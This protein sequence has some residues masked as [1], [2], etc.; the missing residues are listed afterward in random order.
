MKGAREAWAINGALPWLLLAAVRFHLNHVVEL[1]LCLVGVAL[2][3]AVV[4]AMN[5][6]IAS[7]ETSFRA[8]RDAVFGSATHV[9]RSPSGTID[10]QIYKTLRFEH[11]DLASAPVVQGTVMVPGD[12]R[13]RLTLLGIDPLVDQ[14]VRRHAP[15]P[16]GDEQRRV[17][18]LL[19]YPASAWASTE[20]LA[21][22]GITVGQSIEVVAAAGQ[23]EITVIAE[24]TPGSKLEAIG[25]DGVLMTDISSAQEIL[26]LYGR[27]SR[28]D[29][30]LPEASNARIDALAQHLPA[31][32]RIERTLA[33]ARAVS[34]LSAS[35]YFNLR[36]LSLL[37]LVVGLFIIYNAM[38]FAVVR[39]RR[40]IGRLA[41]IGVT[42]RE[43]L[44]SVLLETLLLSSIGALLGI[45]L[46]I[47]L[48]NELL[49]LISRTV[50]DLYYPIDANRLVLSAQALTHGILL[51]LAGSVLAG[52]APALEAT[53]VAP[54][55]AMT[56][57]QLERR[58]HRRA[59][60]LAGVAV[61]V[62]MLV[63]ML[64][65]VSERSLV[66]GYVVLLFMVV[67]GVL[68][69][70]GLVLLFS[71]LASSLTQ[72]FLSPQWS[73]GLR[74]LSAG[75]SRSAVA[76]AALGVALATT[77]GMAV[78]VD[79]FRAS[80]RQ[81]L[82]ITLE[83]DVYV[84]VGDRSHG[85]R[86]SDELVSQ[87]AR[88]PEVRALSVS[89]DSQVEIDGV[90]VWLK[91]L[92]VDG[93]RYRDIAMID[94]A[95]DGWQSLSQPNAVLISEPLAWRERLRV[96]DELRLPVHGGQHAFKVAGVFRDYGSERG[97]IMMSRSQYV[98]LFANTGY[99]GVGVHG[100][101]GVSVQQLARAVETLTAQQPGLS[102]R[103]NRFIRQASFEIF[104]RTFLI[105]RVMQWLATLVA[106]V[107]VV[108]ALMSMALERLR[109]MAVLRAQ[110][111]TRLELVVV[112]QLQNA[113]L[114]LCAGLLACPLGIAMSS[115]LV[116]VINQRAFGWSTDFTLSST[117][118]LSTGIL[119]VVA[120][121]VAGAYPSWRMAN[122]P[123]ADALRDM[124]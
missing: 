96:G 5:L 65:W 10:E 28:I 85:N 15:Q 86:I 53:R 80:F 83:A 12:N 38:T 26:N 72:S 32:V 103:S 93:D 120:A 17:R 67:M 81:W 13:Q 52:L 16:G 40:V 79:S 108:S 23:I 73:L 66:V 51:A 21:R 111:M 114:G 48:G 115:V 106:C 107:G 30:T 121:L 59:P 42:R 20:T 7:A 99:S 84:G 98:T 118:L 87:M 113:L 61:M 89:I 2:G 6:A 82:N 37:A 19:L 122:A 63:V 41:A 14:A 36:M 112:V 24:I 22:L 58:V 91:A 76:V 92:E 78:M 45:G 74:G 60:T 39:R 50:D 119:A 64:L 88:L 8:A 29:L 97:L 47:V 70:P 109:E 100:E 117:V 1:L 11:R 69:A 101:A 35:F 49:T 110:G 71:R 68:L 56:S 34:S 95:D 123:P 94:G 57:V 3:V 25:L 43:L 54:N 62:A 33:S 75:L 27:L 18:D 102:V 104:E 9:I 116:K 90:G 4:I 77:I 44:V 46:G 55:A 105:T 124:V 31:D